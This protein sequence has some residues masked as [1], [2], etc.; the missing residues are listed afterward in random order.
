MV[1][2]V[3]FPTTKQGQS[4][5]GP[6]HVIVDSGFGASRTELIP[7]PGS[8]AARLD[9]HTN[10]NK[11]RTTIKILFMAYPFIFD[12]CLIE[13]YAMSFRLA[14]ITAMPPPVKTHQR[15]SQNP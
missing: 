15:T 12:H 4:N 5:P 13:I 7:P 11:A 10:A 3:D 1:S 6:Q 2:A 8:A 9:A 14:A